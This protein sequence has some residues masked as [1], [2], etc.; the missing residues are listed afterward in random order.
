M[1]IDVPADV[2]TIPYA[3]KKIAE[4]KARRDAG[5]SLELPRPAHKPSQVKGGDAE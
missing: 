2:Y 1:G 5:E 4:A 3:V